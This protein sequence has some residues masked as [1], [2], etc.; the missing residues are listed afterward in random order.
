M[1]ARLLF[2]LIFLS[3][4]CSKLCAQDSLVTVKTGSRISDVLTAPYIYSHPAFI[5]GTVFYRNGIV[6]A[7]KMNYNSLSDQMLFIDPKGDTLALND[8]KTIHFI[9]LDKDTFYYID[10]YAK[11]VASNSVVKL[12][13]RKVWEVADVRKMGTHNRPATG[14]NVTSIGNL[15]DGFGR[16]YN[17]VL[18][19]DV[20][21]RKRSYYYFGDM[22]NSFVPASRKNLLTFFS[23]KEDMLA[24]YLK[25]HK[26]NFNRRNDLEKLTQFLGQNY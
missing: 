4:G 26:V 5:K 25:E 1:K 19:G 6:A 11:V 23:K 13:E 2:L 7:A 15:T 21:F 16:T 10:G 8:E 17:L 18:D 14:V 22:Y 24:G 3:I 9:T 20:L 12:V